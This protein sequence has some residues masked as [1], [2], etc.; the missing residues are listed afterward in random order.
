MKTDALFVIM[1]IVFLFVAWVA[2][3]GPSRPI[4]TA[5]PFITPV[6]RPGEES[7]GYRIQIP[8]NPID[9]SSYPRQISSGTHTATSTPRDP[10]E[11]NVP[12]PPTTRN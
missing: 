9:A 12:P 5:G 11:R 10:Y 7:Q 3:G 2:T 1:C 4:S 8:T 6:S